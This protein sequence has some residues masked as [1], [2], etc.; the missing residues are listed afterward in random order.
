MFQILPITKK[1]PKAK[2]S[3][4]VQA[5]KIESDIKSYLLRAFA[6]MKGD[7]N[8]MEVAEAVVTGKSG[9]VLAVAEGKK[10]AEIIEGLDEEYQKG[11]L[12]GAKTAASQLN[13]K[14]EL[15]LTR[16]SVNRWKKKN[17]DR[18]VEQI[19]ENSRA[20]IKHVLK[21][22]IDR[23]RH[24]NRIARDIKDSLGLNDRLSIAV[25]RKRAAMEAA[26]VPDA[27]I[28]TTIGRYNEKLLNYRAKLIAR[29]ESSRAING[30]RLELWKQMVDTGALAETSVKRWLTS[31]DERVCDI[32]G[33]LHNTE[34]QLDESFESEG[35]SATEPPIH[36]DCR[37]DMVV[38]EKP[39]K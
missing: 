34:V 20:A 19:G 13:M 37:C 7:L 35:F 29:T 15:D 16:A 18:I 36:P 24:P 2:Y 4:R 39:Q 14:V 32:C 33:P 5:G 8:L 26:G 22:G 23:N 28:E 3:P 9:K 21:E 38:K 1:V 10:I 31:S 27:K 30:G 17:L 25:S 6:T 12:A 11:L